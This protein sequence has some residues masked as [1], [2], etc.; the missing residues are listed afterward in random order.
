MALVCD[1]CN[2]TLPANTRYCPS[3][4]LE[5][6]TQRERVAR[7]TPFDH[8][9]FAWDEP[10]DAPKDYVVSAQQQPDAKLT[11][12]VESL[13]TVETQLADGRV[14]DAAAAIRQL[15]PRVASRPKLRAWHERLHH[16]IEKRRDRVRQRCRELIE[17]LD[18]DTLGSLLAGSAANELDPEEIARVALDAARK[19]YDARLADD[20]AELLRLPPFRT[21]RDDALIAEHR[22]LDA[23]VHRRRQWQHWR[24]S[25]AFLGSVIVVAVV[26]L[27]GVTALAWH[28]SRKAGVTM[29][30]LIGAGVGLVVACQR[31]ITA[32]LRERYETDDPAE[33][34]RQVLLDVSRKRR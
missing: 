34:V 9:V 24:R 7:P 8:D 22:E 12:L 30:L 1:V 27:G 2:V 23:L 28:G 31:P 4:G 18:A 10:A 6:L 3:C 20:A 32:W 19:S 29:L 11:Q 25:V 16:A 5:V 26:V 15:K 21:I 14:L 17:S 33:I 13:R